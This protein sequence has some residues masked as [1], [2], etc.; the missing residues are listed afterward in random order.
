MIG[1]RKPRGFELLVEPSTSDAYG[2]SL[3]ET[4]GSGSTTPIRLTHLPPLRVQRVMPHLLGA[5][6]ASRL[7][8]STL[9][10][11]RHKPIRLEES[12]G[13]RLALVML[14]T[15]PLSKWARVE[16]VAAGIQGMTTEEAYYWYAKCVGPNG[17]RAR[18][19]LRLL[20]ADE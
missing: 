7:P 18:R 4:N 3:L 5:I 14:A 10:P 1:I 12:A 15:A 8:N 17:R 6:K 19:A 9:S 16:A 13:V 20:L 2:V 11:L